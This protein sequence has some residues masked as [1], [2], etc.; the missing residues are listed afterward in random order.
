MTVTDERT[1]VILDAAIG[2]FL[3]YGYRKTA[4]DDVAKAAGLS[5]QGLYL[6]YR[7]KDVLFAAVLE[8]MVG[9]VREAALA[10][11]GRVDAPLER[12]VASAL[13]AL[14]GEA[15][16]ASSASVGELLRAAAEVG[17]PLLARLH[18]DVVA[19]LVD[20]LETSGVAGAWRPGG[21]GAEELAEHL[22]LVSS[23]VKQLDAPVDVQLARL[24]VA[25]RIV[26]RGSDADGRA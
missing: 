5:R 17:G 16:T 24:R 26:L 23:A 10:E 25:V 12:R 18:D 13:E 14:H 9:Q 20:V 15:A 3:R 19:A 22:Y 21:V 8:R 7:A 6:H 11:L 1:R 4:M 2:L